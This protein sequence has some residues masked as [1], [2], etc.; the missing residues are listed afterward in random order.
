MLYVGL[1]VLGKVVN[2]VDKIYCLRGVYFLGN[3]KI[4]S[5]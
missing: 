3:G 4:V 2:K 5:K 1:S